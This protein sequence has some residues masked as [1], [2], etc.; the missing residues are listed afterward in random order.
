MKLSRLP[1][2][3]RV[4]LGRF[5]TALAGGVIVVCMTSGLLDW[6]GFSPSF[7][8]LLTEF[9]AA[10]LLLISFLGPRTPNRRRALGLSMPLV[11]A[12]IIGIAVSM[13]NGAKPVE[14][15]L[16]AREILTPVLFLSAFLC[17]PISDVLRRRLLSVLAILMALQV[18]VCAIKF[19]FFGVNEKAWIGT[20]TQSAGQLGLLMPAMAMGFA[21]AFGLVRSRIALAGTCAL[22]IA[23]V[24]V[25]S[26]KRATMFLVPAIPLLTLAI[27][28]VIGHFGRVR[29]ERPGVAAVRY[30]SVV[31][32]VS[33]IVG[34]GSLALIPSLNAENPKY[35]VYGT[36]SVVDYIR[37]YLT[38]DYDSPMNMSKTSV[39]DNQ[40]IQLGRLLL[41]KRAVGLS[42]DQP[43][44]VV[45]AGH[46]GGWLLEHRF[47]PHKGEDVLY[48]RVGL[49]GP[50]GLLIRHLFEIGWV[51]VAL[52]VAWMLALVASLL[53]SSLK[54]PESVLACGAMTSVAVL[55]F[56][57]TF[58]SEMT[59]NSGVFMPI[60]A[61][62]VAFALRSD[63]ECRLDRGC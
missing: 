51:G 28:L 63:P 14:Q 27:W 16:F 30:L 52:V 11:A 1:L 24:G 45:L 4:T 21:W 19:L 58:Y 2:T 61:L 8:R 9:L 50:S 35:L 54:M 42:L 53:K 23:A 41:L 26:E 13:L 32:L 15:M 10:A 12:T 39:D 56:D 59:W 49:R 37:V 7:S 3:G 5:A 18:I 25:V 31:A 62:L 29:R 40:N 55:L 57:Y 22:M 20:M 48:D 6:V 60:F 17:A 33:V 38:R 43:L 46:G 44:S 36:N 34:F 47:L